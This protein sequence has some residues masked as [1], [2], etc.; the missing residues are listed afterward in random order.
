MLSRRETL[1]Q[2]IGSRIAGDPDHV[3]LFQR[4]TEAEIPVAPGQVRVE[5]FPIG[6]DD[7]W[8]TYFKPRRNVRYTLHFAV[9]EPSAA[10]ST[11]D[12]NASDASPRDI[13]V[14]LQVRG[15]TGCF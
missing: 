6:T 1:T 8:G 9:V 3:F 4:G 15:A 11:G 14:R 5:Q 13:G 12:S 7:S 2:W 10:G